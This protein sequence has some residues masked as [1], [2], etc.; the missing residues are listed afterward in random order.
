[1]IEIVEFL[2]EDGRSP[3]AKWFNRLSPQAAAKVSKAVIRMSLGNL[4]NV[5]PKGAGVSACKIDWGP[6]YR[7]YLGQDG[8]RLVILLGGGTKRRQQTDIDSAK[9]HWA[10]YKRR[11]R[12]EK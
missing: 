11:K 3:Y 4:S 9:T 5:E 7:I 1:M 10:G 12:L 6:G 8:D 2:G